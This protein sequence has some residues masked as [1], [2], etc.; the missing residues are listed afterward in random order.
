MLDRGEPGALLASLIPARPHG[1][2]PEKYRRPLPVLAVAFTP[3]GQIAASGYHEVTIWNQSGQLLR[4]ITNVTQRVRAIAFDS[5]GRN[6]AIAGG[7]PGRGGELNL[8]DYESGAFKTNLLRT[9]DEIISLAFSPERKLLACAGTDNAIHVF[10]GETFAPTITIQQHADWVTAIAFNTNGT[11]IASAGRDRTARIYDTTSGNLETTYTGQN[12]PLYAVA[13]LPDGLIASGGRDKSLHIWDSKEGKKKSDIGGFGGEINA[14]LATSDFIFTAS[15]DGL[16]KQHA[17]SDRKL[18]HT[19][20]GHGDA[21]Y[22]LAYD[23]ASKKL[24]SGSYD[25]VLNIWNVESGELEKT[26][27]AAPGWSS[28]R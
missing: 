26:F 18:V 3:D 7:Q 13:C 27:V 12:S 2:P 23:S 1:L 15:G 6:L 28:T 9:S 19:F 24:V 14:L 5:T 21:V 22:A 11:Q 4:R 10:H 16:V 20:T 25:G 8:Y 17:I